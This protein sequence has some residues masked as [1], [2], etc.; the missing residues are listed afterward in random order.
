[1][2]EIITVTQQDPNSDDAIR[3]MDELSACLQSITG[4][5]GRGSFDPKDVCVP[6]SVFVIARDERGEALGCGAIRPIDENIAEIKRMYSKVKGRGVGKLM[7]SYLEKQAQSF[8]YSVLWLE[9]RK[10]NQGAVSFYISQGYHEIPNYGKYV[11][12]DEAICFGKKLSAAK[13]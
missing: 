11:G 13:V 12:K 3:L 10:V 2:K 9:T 1:M 6:R 7:L 8:G 4:D 5:S